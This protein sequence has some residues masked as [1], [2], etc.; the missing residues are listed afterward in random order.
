MLLEDSSYKKMERSQIKHWIELIK[1]NADT[2]LRLICD[3]LDMESIAEG[4]LE[5]RL[6]QQCIGEIIRESSRVSSYASAKT[7]L[8]RAEHANFWGAFVDHDRTMKV[9]SNLIG[10]AL[11][12]RGGRIDHSKVKSE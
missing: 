9:L 12:F 6:K 8:L 4:K 10:N 3:I 1:R 11:N 7:V 5:L 2:S